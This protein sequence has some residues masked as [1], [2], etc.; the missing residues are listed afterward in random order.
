MF[1]VVLEEII[2]SPTA[3]WGGKQS[4]V[5]GMALYREHDLDECLGKS[6]T[7]GCSVPVCIHYL[8]HRVQQRQTQLRASATLNCVLIDEND[9][10]RAILFMRCITSQR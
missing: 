2:L 1:W 7:G 4:Q 10:L 8:E 3:N 5:P 9:H 6:K